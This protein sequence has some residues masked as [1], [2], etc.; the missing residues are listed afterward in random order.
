MAGTRPKRDRTQMNLDYALYLLER[1]GDQMSRERNAKILKIAE[2]AQK[3][4]D[5]R[6]A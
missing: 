4:I 1:F 6:E 5:E 3:K 2:R